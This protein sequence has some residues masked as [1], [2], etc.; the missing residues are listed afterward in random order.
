MPILPP[1]RALPTPIASVRSVPYLRVARSV[2]CADGLERPSPGSPM[3]FQPLGSDREVSS[4]FQLIAGTNRDLAA[5][6]RDGRFRE[7]LLARMNLW[8]LDRKST[9]LN[10][11]HLGIS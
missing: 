4:E 5:F 11:S 8:T 7:D 1:W 6:V 2:S 10:S 9:R 3:S